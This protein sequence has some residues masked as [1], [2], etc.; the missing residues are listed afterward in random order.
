MVADFNEAAKMNSVADMFFSPGIRCNPE[1]LQ[2]LFVRFA[3]PAFNL[4][5]CYIFI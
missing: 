4:L 2:F 5:N 3:K 1:R